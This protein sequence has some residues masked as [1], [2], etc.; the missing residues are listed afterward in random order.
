MSVAIEAEGLERRRGGAM[1]QSCKRDTELVARLGM[2]NAARGR[3]DYS[4]W[5][6]VDREGCR[7]YRAGV[8]VGS[9]FEATGTD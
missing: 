6:C 5:Q 1:C 2:R 9:S 8:R 3:V 7:L 4:S